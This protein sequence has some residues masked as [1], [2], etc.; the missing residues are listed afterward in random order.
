MFVCV[1][2]LLILGYQTSSLTSQIAKMPCPGCITIC[3][4][5]IQA[6]KL[7]SRN[8]H[9]HLH[10]AKPPPG[11]FFSGSASEDLSTPDVTICAG[12]YEQDSSSPVYVQG[13]R[14]VPSASANFACK[15]EMKGF[16]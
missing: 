10:P 8:L 7:Q 4:E 11:K 14:H 12:G 1:R 13:T 6:Q 15:G 5:Y 3:T 9:L 16:R 2:A